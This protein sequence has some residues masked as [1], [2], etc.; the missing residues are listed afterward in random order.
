MEIILNLLL[1]KEE[2]LNI[3]ILCSLH[4]DVH[5][6][7]DDGRWNGCVVFV[8]VCAKDRDP[9]QNVNLNLERWT[10]GKVGKTDF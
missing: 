5:V 1:F 9:K 6:N 10:G 8:H 3:N 2:K 4:C 7:S